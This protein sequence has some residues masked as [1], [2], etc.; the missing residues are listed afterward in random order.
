MLRYFVFFVFSGLVV[1]GITVFFRLGGHKAVVVERRHVAEFFVVGKNHLG[2]YHKINAVITEVENWAQQHNIPCS[3]TF[4]EYYDDPRQKAEDRLSS[5]GGCVLNAPLPE[6]AIKALPPRFTH[7]PIPARER[8]VAV[9]EGAPSIGPFKVYPTV[10][11]FMA[12][13]RLKQTGA[14]I[15]IYDISG[16]RTA[17]TEYLFDFE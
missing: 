12:A 5:F 10:E 13:Q 16:A 7:K 4:G 14:V 3:R 17:R 2:A 1:F 11:E 6:E 15:E 9:F 8:V